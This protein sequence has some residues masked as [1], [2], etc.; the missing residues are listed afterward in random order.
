MLSAVRPSMRGK[1]FAPSLNDGPYTVSTPPRRMVRAAS[2]PTTDTA[3]KW[4]ALWMEEAL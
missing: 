1:K 2:E 3:R 4:R